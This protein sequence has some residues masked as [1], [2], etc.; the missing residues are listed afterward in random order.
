MSCVCVVFFF[1]WAFWLLSRSLTVGLAAPERLVLFM[2][3]NT[4][5]PQFYTHTL[6]IIQTCAPKHMHT[7]GTIH[8]NFMHEQTCWK[9]KVCKGNSFF[10]FNKHV[11][12]LEDISW[13]GPRSY[14][15]TYLSAHREGW[16]IASAPH[17]ALA[18][19]SGG[20][21]WESPGCSRRWSTRT[22]GWVTSAGWRG[23][24]EESDR[25]CPWAARRRPRAPRSPS[26]CWWAWPGWERSGCGDS[27]G[28]SSDR[29]GSEEQQCR[30]T[31]S[32]STRAA[33]RAESVSS[34]YHHLSQP[35]ME[36]LVAEVRT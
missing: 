34:F 10:F 19:P 23:C 6:H 14:L 27:P 25:C 8:N 15:P 22:S 28:T 29:S 2:G 9:K 20:L 30:Q 26:P 18:A 13:Q 1:Q 5:C 7:H 32:I 35:P 16:M 11:F 21:S 17:R 31:L 24:W 4:F 33:H 36:M 12:H 3:F